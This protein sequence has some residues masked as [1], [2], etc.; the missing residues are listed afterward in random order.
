[1]GAAIDVPSILQ[2]AATASAQ[3][4]A[5]A[6]QIMQSIS[7]NNQRGAESATAEQTIGAA[8]LIIQGVEN[9]AKLSVQNKNQESLAEFGLDQNGSASDVI[10]LTA[11]KVA[12][13]RSRM[14]TAL[15][16]IRQKNSVEFLDDPLS[17]ISNI[18]TINDDINEYNQSNN[19]SE[20]QLAI[21]QRL[22]KAQDDQERINAA[23]ATTITP[24]TIQA[25]AEQTAANTVLALGKIK[26]DTAQFNNAAIM[27]AKSLSV[28]GVT[29]QMD[30]ARLVDSQQQLAIAKDTEA[31]EDARFALYKQEKEE[32]ENTMA[33]ILQQA[34]AGFDV[35]HLPRIDGSQL[36]L[37]KNLGGANWDKIGYAFGVGGQTAASGRPV[38]SATPAGA[39]EVMFKTGMQPPA[40]EVPIAR[41]IGGL[42]RDASINPAMKGDMQAQVAYINSAVEDAVEGRID[43]ASGKRVNGWLSNVNNTDTKNIYNP[44]DIGSIVNTYPA[45][46]QTQLF[47]Q[48]LSP[49]LEAANGS[50]VKTDP[51]S[52]LTQGLSLV[53]KGQM[54]ATQLDSDLKVLIGA[55][56]GTNNAVN[57][58]GKYGLPE[59]KTFE[60]NGVDWAN[61]AQ[62]LY[63]IT[64]LV[65][66]GASNNGLSAVG[67]A[68]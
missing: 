67:F 41:F 10:A 58:Y 16:N 45:V 44:K 32:T 30:A 63:Y 37:Y 66:L 9:T 23:T 4:N 38:L 55:A 65:T 19:D 2:S 6:A 36:K 26:Q 42:A 40:A 8:Q 52:I 14:S 56:I 33:G 27:Q 49:Q 61:D 29:V 59:Q 3:A 48:L 31:R 47:K 62:R 12:D 54:S 15:D 39:A 60:I 43:P 64:T 17:Y 51:S 24:A 53:A 57:N 22:Q 35:M 7:D 13:D 5:G 21:L 34:N 28:A 20:N 46:A 11:S 18:F 68:P 1:M 25:Q 50:A